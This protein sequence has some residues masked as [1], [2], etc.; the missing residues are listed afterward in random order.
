MKNAIFITLVIFV[1]L[2]ISSPIWAEQPD[3]PLPGGKE[4][5]G[6]GTYLLEIGDVVTI[7]DSNGYIIEFNRLAQHSGRYETWD[8]A[9]LRIT[10]LEGNKLTNEQGVFYETCVSGQYTELEDRSVGSLL[11]FGLTVFVEDLDVENEKITL[12]FP[13]N[14]H[15][16]GDGTYTLNEGDIVYSDMAYE[17]IFKNFSWVYG[18]NNTKIDTAEIIVK[19]WESNTLRELELRKDIIPT[20]LYEFGLVVNANKI[21]PNIGLIELSVSSTMT[22]N[23]SPGWNLVSVP[24]YYVRDSPTLD[25]YLCKIGRCIHFNSDLCRKACS[26]SKMTVEGDVYDATH[27]CY[28]GCEDPYLDSEVF[29]TIVYEDTCREWDDLEPLKFLRWDPVNGEYLERAFPSPPYS[30]WLKVD[31]KCHIPFGGHPL[32]IEGQKMYTGWNAIGAPMKSLQIDEIKGDCDITSG[33]WRYSNELNEFEK[34]SSLS[35]TEGNFI[36]VSGDC[37][38]G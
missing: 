12:T 29:G 35:A 33:P 31:K 6:Y 38:L 5:S 11:Y 24:L 17:I 28:R 36:K 27:I 15:Y 20:D 14:K 18:A 25:P 37:T 9:I 23:F 7:D 2:L 26:I 3:I 22:V 8:C 32:T 16:Y 21:Y 34:M 19:D 4:Y 13:Q 10:D 30:Y 1:A